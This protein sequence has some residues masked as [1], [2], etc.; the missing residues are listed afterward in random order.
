[1]FKIELQHGGNEVKFLADVMLPRD[2][3]WLAAVKEAT[4]RGRQAFHE[5]MTAYRNRQS[6]DTKQ[7][8]HLQERRTGFANQALD[9][10]KSLTKAEA[11]LRRAI[12][13]G[14]D[15]GP[16][17]TR[18]DTH[19]RQLKMYRGWESQIE[20]DIKALTA[21]MERETSLGSVTAREEYAQECASR[22]KEFETKLVE[23][24]QVHGAGLAEAQAGREAAAADRQRDWPRAVA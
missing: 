2:A 13:G 24:L 1:M 10:K 23:F 8:A 21:K 4:Q 15:P 16:I 3:E 12:A 5:R 18:V 22:I 14:K 9:E 17:Q 7:L 6:D 19:T 11:D 20:A